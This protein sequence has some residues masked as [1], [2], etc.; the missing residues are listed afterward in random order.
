MVKAPEKFL[1]KYMSRGKGVA[2]KKA[3]RVQ[4]REVSEEELA[5]LK[6][7]LQTVWGIY[8]T[9]EIKEILSKKQDVKLLTIDGINVCLNIDFTNKGIL[10][11]YELD[12]GDRKELAGARVYKQ[13]RIIINRYFTP[14][15]GI[16]ELLKTTNDAL[17]AMV[18]I[19][20]DRELSESNIWNAIE[21]GEQIHLST[22]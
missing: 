7:N 9:P 11:E 4:M 6:Q 12:M 13:D 15:R 8:C 18:D 10:M 14:E 2:G 21:K 20:I 17:H 22:I 3:S 19:L 1:D 16:E 5:R